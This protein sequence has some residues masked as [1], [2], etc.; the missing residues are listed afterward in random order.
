M[1]A[2]RKSAAA[3]EKDLRLAMFRI[4]RG[5][6]RT[7]ATKLSIASVASEAGVSP[8]LIHNHYPIIAD[9]IRTAQGRSNR[10]QRDAKQL[11]LKAER[12][13][14]R[15]LREEMASLKADRDKLASIN[16]VLM[17]ENAVLRA[18][19]KSPHVLSVLSSL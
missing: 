3:R 7:K 8:A 1:S 17:A 4:Q 12:D 16:E 6:A 13:K 5:R 19:R 11:E 9:E 15:T 10:V 14:V 18:Q 2:D